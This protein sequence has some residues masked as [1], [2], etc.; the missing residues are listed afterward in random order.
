MIP[1]SGARCAGPFPPFALPNGYRPR[2]SA[3]TPRTAHSQLDRNCAP[4]AASA[5]CHDAHAARPQSQ[6][7]CAVRL[8]DAVRLA[9]C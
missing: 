1:P 6:D 3:P 9:G 5:D 2:G 7:V 4:A 8:Y